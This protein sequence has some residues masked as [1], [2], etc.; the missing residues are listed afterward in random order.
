[1]FF[2]GNT[3]TL[4]YFLL[5]V[6]LYFSHSSFGC[7]SAKDS[8]TK[9]RVLVGLSPCYLPQPGIGGPL[10]M[11][12]NRGK[13]PQGGSRILFPEEGVIAET[14]STALKGHRITMLAIY[15]VLT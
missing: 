10:G 14:T 9:K 12:S 7:D 15:C 4:K 13:V 3:L 6:P 1:M 5:L 8:D 11:I 2:N